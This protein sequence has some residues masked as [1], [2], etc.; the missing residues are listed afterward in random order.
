V[1]VYGAQA[2]LCAQYLGK[3]ARVIFDAE[4]VWRE[5]TDHENRR[6]AAVIL[7]A[8]RVLFEGVRA[9]NDDPDADASPRGAEPVAVAPRGEGSASAEDLPS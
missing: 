7:R 1:E 2:R 5:W 6:R 4:L 9:A 8:R 3:G